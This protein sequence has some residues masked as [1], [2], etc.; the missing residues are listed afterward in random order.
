MLEIR[1]IYRSFPAI[2]RVLWL[3][4]VRSHAPD[5]KTCAKAAASL[6]FDLGANVACVKASG[7]ADV[8]RSLDDG[9]SI[10]EERHFKRLLPE[11]Q[12]EVIVAN[13]AVKAE[14]AAHVVQVDGSRVFV[15][16]NRVP[17]A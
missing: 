10:G 13:L 15:Y 9:S 6:Q 8:G 2:W 3:D 1:G 12:H 4:I 16:L 7:D 14:P 5:A 11:L 17:S